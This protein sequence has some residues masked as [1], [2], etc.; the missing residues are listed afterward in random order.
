M[1]G[2]AHATGGSLVVVSTDDAD[3]K[4]LNS[5]IKRSFT[6]APLQQ[7]SRWLDGGY[8]LL[9]LLLLLLL[10]FFRRGGSV[11]L[12]KRGTTS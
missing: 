1:R 9:P 10:P 11:I 8:Y 12:P 5:D 7:G 3:V 2:A 4:R 6:S